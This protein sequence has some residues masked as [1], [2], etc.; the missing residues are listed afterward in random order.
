MGVTSAETIFRNG[1]LWTGRDDPEGA[2]A[3]AVA[4]GRIVAV[5]SDHD[6]LNLRGSDTRVVDLGGQTLLPGFVDAHAH[7]WKIGHLLTTLLDVRGVETTL[8]ITDLFV[9]AAT[10]GDLGFQ[11]GQRLAVVHRISTAE[12]AEF[13]ALCANNRGWTVGS[14]DNFEEAFNWLNDADEQGQ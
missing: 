11:R 12:R 13:F 14:F 8:T 9:L 4:A 6:V 1:V 5:G 10:F 3:L 7:I 2:T